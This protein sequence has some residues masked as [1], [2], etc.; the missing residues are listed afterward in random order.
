MRQHCP[1]WFSRKG[2]EMLSADR[3][4]VFCFE[5]SG[6]EIQALSCPFCDGHDLYVGNSLEFLVEN[7]MSVACLAWAKLDGK[8][9]LSFGNGQYGQL[10]FPGDLIVITNEML[11]GN[12]EGYLELCFAPAVGLLDCGL[13]QLEEDF[14][15]FAESLFEVYFPEERASALTEEIITD[16]RSSL[17][18]QD[19][20]VH[21]IDITYCAPE[22]VTIEE[23]QGYRRI[24]EA[25]SAY[26]LS[27][28]DIQGLSGPGC[29]VFS[30]W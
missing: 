3:R 9:P 24:E 17:E 21:S 27:V 13:E 10:V 16:L 20:N 5:K 22:D 1:H 25:V 2:P 19:G 6:K 12:S 11:Q 30:M 14:R 7:P 23:V 26:F 8:E 4:S 15:V 28:K 18:F 29:W